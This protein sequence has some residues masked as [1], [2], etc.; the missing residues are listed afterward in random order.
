MVLVLLV[1]LVFGV[2][3]V[4]NGRPFR[5]IIIDRVHF[6]I[7][8]GSCLNLGLAFAMR[9][10]GGWRLRCSRCGNIDHYHRSCRFSKRSSRY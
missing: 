10:T 2:R 4:M 3:I 5:S 6:P 8:C 9:Y 7:T 1:L